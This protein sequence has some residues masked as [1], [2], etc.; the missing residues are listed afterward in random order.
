MAAVVGF[1]EV[2]IDEQG[3]SQGVPRLTGKSE[4]SQTPGGRANETAAD[5]PGPA[6]IE[7]DEIG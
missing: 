1:V 2:D 4:G 7:S 5:P 3:T 6:E